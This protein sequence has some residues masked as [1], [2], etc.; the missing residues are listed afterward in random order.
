[1]YRSQTSDT[2]AII[3]E[4]VCSVTFVSQRSNT[5]LIFLLYLFTA[6][7][8]ANLYFSQLEIY[9]NSQSERIYFDTTNLYL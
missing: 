5:G 6:Q 2:N 3:Y 9:K 7:H 4:L 1:M 8:S